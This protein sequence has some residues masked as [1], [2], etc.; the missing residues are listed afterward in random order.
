MAEARRQPPAAPKISRMRAAGYF[1]TGEPTGAGDGG[2]DAAALALSAMPGVPVEGGRLCMPHPVHT[3]MAASESRAGARVKSC[4]FIVVPSVMDKA[5]ACQA[6]AWRVRQVAAAS[7]PA[8]GN[9]RM[10]LPVAAAMA[11]ISA[12]ATTGTPGSPTPPKG[13]P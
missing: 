6:G 3:S 8:S 5:P 7:C 10:R 12:G 9:C 13:T 1:A 11:F 2:A 4:S